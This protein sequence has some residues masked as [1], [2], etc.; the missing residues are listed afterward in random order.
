[1]ENSMAFPLMALLATRPLIWKWTLASVLVLVWA[2][3]MT[4]SYW[5]G[6]EQG[7]QSG[8]E[9]LQPVISKL[10]SEKL[11]LE[12]KAEE[13]NEFYLTQIAK[14]ETLVTQRSIELA[15]LEQEKERVLAEVVGKFRVQ[16][17]R[18]QRDLRYERERIATMVPRDSVVV[19]P[20]GLRVL[21]NQAVADF[22]AA[23]GA[24][25]DLASPG[26]VS[27][28]QDPA[29][30]A[31]TTETFDA[32][33]FTEVLLRNVRQYN[34]LAARYVTLQSLVKHYED[35]LN[36]VLKKRENPS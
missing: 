29:Q 36:R 2:G 28:V 4:F 35:Q 24:G 33:A 34:E 26:S 25:D 21:H 22:D 16:V 1:M 13:A 7:F 30:V 6:K 8:K 23:T 19:A 5:K 31:G 12:R 3:S 11:V 15:E 17:A 32:T 14:F 27:P 9:T 10:S 18:I 20:S